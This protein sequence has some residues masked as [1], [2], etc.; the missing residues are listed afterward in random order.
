VSGQFRR[1]FPLFYDENDV[2][3]RDLLALRGFFDGEWSNSVKV[4]LTYLG[5]IPRDS[6]AGSD[7]PTCLRSPST[8]N[9]L[10]PYERV[11]SGEPHKAVRAKRPR[12][13]W[14]DSPLELAI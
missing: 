9:Q 1:I 11:K 7:L 6:R 14:G 10:L 3:A 2:T 5:G 13:I 8:V 12:G 4:M